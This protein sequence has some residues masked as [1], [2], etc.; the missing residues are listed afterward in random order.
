[1]SKH[2][3]DRAVWLRITAVGVVASLSSGCGYLMQ[4]R[5][6]AVPAAVPAMQASQTL[7]PEAGK[8]H[9]V[10]AGLDG[11]VGKKVGDSYAKTFDGGKRVDAN[12]A[13]QGTEGLGE[14]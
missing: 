10:V 2:L 9:K 5:D 11:T 13:F 14:N 1:M 4:A 3:S 7:N 8:N 6:H 12:A